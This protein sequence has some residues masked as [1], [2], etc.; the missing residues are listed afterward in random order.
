MYAKHNRPA[1]HAR[2]DP[3]LNRLRTFRPHWQPT[4][5]AGAWA[6]GLCAIFFGFFGLMQ[7][8]IATGQ[9]GGATFFS[10]RWLAGT[11]LALAGS[12]IGGGLTALWAMFRERERSPLVF[13]AGLLGALVLFFVLGE[14]LIPH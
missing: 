12:G 1:K 9:S 10:N 4:S 6:V 11:A 14:L 5:A 7:I 3:L 2:P 8:L 13:A